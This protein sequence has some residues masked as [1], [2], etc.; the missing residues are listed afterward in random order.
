M[1]DIN[2]VLSATNPEQAEGILSFRAV[3]RTYCLPI[4]FFEIS[5]M[6]MPCRSITPFFVTKN[7]PCSIATSAVFDRRT[8]RLTTEIAPKPPSSLMAGDTMPSSV[9][10]YRANWPTCPWESG[11]VI[12][13]MLITFPSKETISVVSNTNGFSNLDMRRLFS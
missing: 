10:T 6:V 12:A 5:V 3:S 7:I 2:G 9:N 4:M 13:A 11:C 1:N 8:S